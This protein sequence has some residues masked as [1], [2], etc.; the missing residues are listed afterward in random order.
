VTLEG[1]V[2][3]DDSRDEITEVVRRVEGVRLVLNQTKTD[4]EVMSAWG[5]AASE[6][7]VFRDYLARKWILILLALGIVATSWLLARFFTANSE[8]LLAPLVRNMLLRSVLASIISSLLVIGG[9]VLALGALRL[10]HAVMSIL[11]ISGLVVLAVG[12]AFRD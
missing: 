3:D 12:F 2:D 6:L 5:F 7:G 10:T 1:R 8:V 11:G 9:L 4:E